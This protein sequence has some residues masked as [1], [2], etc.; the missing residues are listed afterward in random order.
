MI[1]KTKPILM[2]TKSGN[3]FA[4]AFRGDVKAIEI[5]ELNEGLFNALYSLLSFKAGFGIGGNS[6]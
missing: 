6:F 4:H 2:Q 1:S 5:T 3:C